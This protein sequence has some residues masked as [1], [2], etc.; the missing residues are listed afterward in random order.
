MM[1][2]PRFA[3]WMP[4]AIGLV[5]GCSWFTPTTLASETKRTKFWQGVYLDLPPKN[6]EVTRNSRFDTWTI[7]VFREINDPANGIY[8]K[9]E[10]YSVALEKWRMPRTMWG[11]TTKQ[12]VAT[13]RRDGQSPAKRFTMR[14]RGK[15]ITTKFLTPN[16]WVY[17]K[18]VRL[19]RKTFVQANTG[20]KKLRSKD[21][22][23]ARR[24]VNS[25]AVR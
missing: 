9:T 18:M 5:C 4:V 22:R 7:S 21:A 13:F 16:G 20:F 12:V 14:A 2:C 19:D 23:A 6:A 10:V 11:L 17:E 15:T 24:L 25:L 1:L 8:E 3:K